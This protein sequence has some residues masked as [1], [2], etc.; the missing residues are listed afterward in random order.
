MNIPNEELEPN[1][2]TI[3]TKA[4][5]EQHKKCMSELASWMRLSRKR[6]EQLLDEL[7]EERESYK[8]YLTSYE[9]HKEETRKYEICQDIKELGD[10][11]H[12][13]VEGLREINKPC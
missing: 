12:D 2:F 9:Q 3:P 13:A 5:Y 11:V 7:Y 6:Q 1:G 4:E 8:L 10:K